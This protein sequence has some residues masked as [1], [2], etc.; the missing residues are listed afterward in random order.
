VWQGRCAHRDRDRA[1]GV[2][3]APASLFVETMAR[4]VTYQ[5][6]LE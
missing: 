4:G 2:H 1:E 6:V 3:S 5:R